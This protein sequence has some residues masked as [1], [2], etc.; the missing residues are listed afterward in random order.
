MFGMISYLTTLK[1]YP[2][3]DVEFC[4]REHDRSQAGPGIDKNL[5]SQ[6]GPGAN[7]NLKRWNL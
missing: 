5:I 1:P 7:I 4:L 2:N 3:P 6:A